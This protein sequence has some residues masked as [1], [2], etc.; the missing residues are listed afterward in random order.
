M[1]NRRQ[2]FAG[3]AATMAGLTV[4]RSA[5]AALPEPVIQT[6]VDTAAPL[7]PNTGRPYNPVVTLNG[8][9]LPWRMNNGVK[10]FHLVAEPVVRE[11]APGFKVNMWGYNGQS[12]GPTIEVVEGDRVRI[13]VTNKLPE[14]TQRHGWRRRLEPARHSSG[15][16]LRLRV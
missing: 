12:P 6:S 5:L 15:Q 4:A 9:S 11:M 16:D 8:W 13:F 2:F 7:V 3:A 10:E 14:H 1:S